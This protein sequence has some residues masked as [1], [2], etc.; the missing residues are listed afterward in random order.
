M[1]DVSIENL[2]KKKGKGPRGILTKQSQNEGGVQGEPWFPSK[3]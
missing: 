1:K 2:H 3:N